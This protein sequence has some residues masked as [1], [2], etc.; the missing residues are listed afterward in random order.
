MSRAQQVAE[1]RAFQKVF[2]SHFIF[3]LRYNLAVSAAKPYQMILFIFSFLHPSFSV[4]SYECRS[5]II[6]LRSFCSPRGVVRRLTVES[7]AAIL[8][9]VP[10]AHC[11]MGAITIR[12]LAH[13][14]T[15]RIS[16]YFLLFVSWSSQRFTAVSGRLPTY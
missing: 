11:A 1:R 16:N 3:S 10:F 8:K 13:L 2:L 14:E 9:R 15:L 12:Y 7:V 6:L 5:L 4:S